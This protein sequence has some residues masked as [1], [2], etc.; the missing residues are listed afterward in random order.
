VILPKNEKDLTAKAL[1]I[2]ENCR[3]SQASRAAAYRQYAQWCETGR[4]SGGL[5]LGNLLEGHIDRL[6]SHLFSPTELRFAI[7]YENLYPKEWLE[8]GAIAARVVSREWERQNIDVLFGHG[9]KESLKY[10]ACLL[11]QLAGQDAD[12]NF[13][14]RGARLVMP[15]HFG[16]YDESQNSI[17][18]QEAV[19]E[20]V[21]LN[22]HEV[23]RRIRN[24]PDAEKLF[25]KILGNATK[26][27]GVGMPSNFMHQVLS[28]A[29]LDT[30]QSLT[31]RPGGIVQLSNDPSSLLGGPQV[32]AELFPMHEVYVKVDDRD[33][34]EDYTTIQLIEPDILVAPRLKHSNL[35][36]KEHQP[37]TLIQG[38]FVA[39][40]LWGRS[41][42]TDL[43]ML[44]AWLTE[45]LD[46][47]K[48]LMGQQ[49]DRLFAFPGYE[50]LSDELYTQFRSTGYIGLP[51]NTS[52]QDLTPK[53]PEQLLPII[54]EI[55]Q[56][57]DRV[58]GFPPVMSGQG[59]QGVRSG[60]HADT[61]MKTGSPRLRDRSLLYER[62][63]NAA[64]DVTLTILQAK[65]AKAYWT[66]PNDEATDFTLKQL[67]D[68]RRI[69]VDS[70]SGSPIYHDDHA[71]LIAWGVKAGIITAESA[72]EQLPF[73]HKDILIARHKEQAA[74]Q[75][76]MAEQHPE[77]LSGKQGK[78]MLRAVE[79][80]D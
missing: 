43:M 24:L 76:Q 11:K 41:E 63:C 7:D 48:R 1:E 21:F 80:G 19:C 47:A 79:H 10:G 62:H 14:F 65:E 50:G 15:W 20:T 25:K 9:V 77:V 2:I 8:K 42:I 18:D 66:N 78:A 30:S 38:N 3:V 13:Y 22:K 26:D 67:M 60:V 28:T 12:E 27:E 69:S 51:P 56:M 40:Y 29:V 4:A 71:Q 64:A 32:A 39:N 37:Y 45:H 70:H 46:D 54:A 53:M 74:A 33:G 72:I 75:K 55:I 23:W 68:D 6:A 35:F 52:A 59:D 31:Q 58:S 5:A 34:G 61:L 16:V 57:M 49:I 73:A 44:Q 17:D 36:V